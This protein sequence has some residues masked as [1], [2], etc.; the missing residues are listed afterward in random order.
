MDIIKEI[1][2]DL[3]IHNLIKDN[4]TN[5]FND[6]MQRYFIAQQIGLGKPIKSFLVNTNHPNGLE[7][8]TLTNTGL[9]FIQNEQSKKLITM[10]IARPQ[11][12]KRYYMATNQFCPK[13]LL[14]L[15]YMHNKAGLN[16]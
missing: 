4:Q 1:K 5:H 3:Q 11:Q 7:I 2:I 14:N 8:H 12:L 9:V 15:G 16:V 13:Y 10:L 6:R